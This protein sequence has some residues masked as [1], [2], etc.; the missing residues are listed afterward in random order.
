MEVFP[1]FK[2]GWPQA[3]VVIFES[4]RTLNQSV[5]SV[6]SNIKQTYV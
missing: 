6:D 3:G 2:E 4:H 5:R 1:S